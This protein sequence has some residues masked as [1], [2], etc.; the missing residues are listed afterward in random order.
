MLA[1][2]QPSAYRRL[3]L[4][5]SPWHHRLESAFVDQFKGLAFSKKDIAETDNLHL[6]LID[7]ETK[8]IKDNKT[9]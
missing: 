7:R 6:T 4:L 3:S 9:K 8:Q 5:K 1:L 2:P